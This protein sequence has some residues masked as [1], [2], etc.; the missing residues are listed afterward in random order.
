MIPL[1]FF[2]VRSRETSG[3]RLVRQAG[4]GRC[5]VTGKAP[6]KKIYYSSSR[7]DRAIDP[8]ADCPPPVLRRLSRRSSD[9]GAARP[10]LSPP[11]PPFSFL[12]PRPCARCCPA[13]PLCAHLA[14]L[15]T[16]LPPLP[17]AR[18]PLAFFPSPSLPYGAQ[19]PLFSPPSCAAC[20]PRPSCVPVPASRSR[21]PPCPPHSLLG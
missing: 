6:P 21:R 11:P 18:P 2:S 3:S 16:S 15:P 12:S 14:L 10:I 5:S 1:G 8:W 4:S 13:H 19:T 17:F 7:E 20:C 9:S